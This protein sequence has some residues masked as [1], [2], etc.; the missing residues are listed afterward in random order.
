MSLSLFVVNELAVEKPLLRL[1]IQC[2]FGLGTGYLY[3]LCAVRG[4]VPADCAEWDRVAWPVDL[5]NRTI[6]KSSAG[7]LGK[8][9]AG[10]RYAADLVLQL[11]A[12]GSGSVA[13]HLT[14]SSLIGSAQR[15]AKLLHARIIAL[16]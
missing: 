9:K 14:V 15:Q 5:T 16:H 3:R 10:G 7:R 4:S 13:F 1:L 2:N 11:P 12:R 6:P 8:R